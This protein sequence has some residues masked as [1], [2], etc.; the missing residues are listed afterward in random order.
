MVAR[1]ALNCKSVRQSPGVTDTDNELL[2]D[3]GNGKRLVAR[4]G[5]DLRHCHAWGRWLA[6]DGKRWQI[7]STGEIVRRAKNTVRSL[8]REA[9]EDVARKHKELENCPDTD[10][11]KATALEKAIERAKAL[12]GHAKRSE[13][14]GRL[15]A[16]IS[17]AASEP[18]V[19]VVPG[20]LDAD[21]FLLNVATGT[22][23]LRTGRIRPH[24]REDLLTKL[25]PVEFDPDALAPTWEKFLTTIF[26][27]NLALI[28][29]VQRLLGYCLTGS[30][31]AQV[32][33]V[34]WGCGA[35]GKSTLLN[36]VLGIL[37]DDYA[38]PAAPGLLVARRSE[39]HSTELASLCGR[40]L[41]VSS[42]TG[43]GNRL[44]EDRVKLLT[45]GDRLSVRRM[46]EDFWEF[47]PSHKLVLCTNH[48]PV[49]TGT[50]HAVWR[51]IHLV[52][53]A[54]TIPEAD[55]D[56]QL[57]EK[58][59]S[60][61]SGIL[62][63]CVRGCMAWQR[64]GLAPPQEVTSATQGYRAE[65][66]ILGGFLGE[67]CVIGREYRCRAGDLYEAYRRWC[68]RGGETAASQRRFGQAIVERDGIERHVSGGKWYLGIAVASARDEEAA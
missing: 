68:E 1:S 57:P 20:Q 41:A 65:Q 16:L 32:L 52:P 9:F 11:Q 56:K 39:Q 50:D 46:R 38:I 60:E 37:G 61:A 2:T 49:I 17:L 22:I 19:P 27:G 28:G 24:R 54:V 14:S 47:S 8:Y 34:F 42:E 31:A 10:T 58:L 4:H 64:E 48:R 51:R 59:R 55:Q 35:N 62:A 6:W 36:A 18:G 67:C 25:A 29:Y 26:D 53:F 43:E 23:D 40:R 13:S 66:D 63:W 33:P 30:V 3:V 7:D 15:H 21:T 44:A 45:G 12:V 5:N